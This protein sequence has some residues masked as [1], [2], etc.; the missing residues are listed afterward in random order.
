MITLAGPREGPTRGFTVLELLVVASVIAALAGFMLHRLSIYQQQAELAAVQRTVEV[1]RVALALRAGHLR[2]HGPDTAI[3]SLAGQNPMTW[4]DKPPANYV[5]EYYSPVPAEIRPGQWY[6]NRSNR[7]VTYLLH[8]G[9]IFPYGTS[10]RLQYTVKLLHLPEDNVKSQA[11]PKNFSV[12]LIQ[13][14]GDTESVVI[15]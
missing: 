8:P 6:F 2:A 14:A 12:A 3:A 5:G 9:K 11:A 15:R 13:V 4:L 1:M 10:E 7:T